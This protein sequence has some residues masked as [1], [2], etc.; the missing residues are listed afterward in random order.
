MKNSKLSAEKTKLI[1]QLRILHDDS[2]EGAARLEE[3]SKIEKGMPVKAPSQIDPE[4]Q[5]VS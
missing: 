2:L 4:T 1:K 5:F 3:V